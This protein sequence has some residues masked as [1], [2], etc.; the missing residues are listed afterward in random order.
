[1]VIVIAHGR[2]AV[3]KR[4]ELMATLRW[5]QDESRKE[6][7]CLRYGFYTSV[8]DPDEFVAVEEWESAEALGTHFGAPSI[9]GFGE[10]VAGLIGGTPEIKIHGIA[11]TNDFPDLNGLE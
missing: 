10:R 2:C 1:M 9:A 4:E 6:P 7:G 11:K 5:M 3:G 8:S